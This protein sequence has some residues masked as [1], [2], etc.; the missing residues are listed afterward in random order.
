MVAVVQGS[1][2]Q[3]ESRGNLNGSFE[4]GRNGRTPTGWQVVR[5]AGLMDRKSA[6][7][8]KASLRVEAADLSDSR[9]ES[10]PIELEIGKLYEVR[11]WVRT[12]QLA[13]RDL[14]RSPVA[15]GAAISMASLPFDYHSESIG[16]SRGWTRLRL[17]F[18]ATRAQ[19][20]VV[21]LVGP[22][23]QVNGRA[24][25]DEIGVEEAPTA[26]EWP[27]DS[28]LQTFGPAYRYPKAGW[29]YLHIEGQPYE[30]GYQHGYLLAPEIGRYLDRCALKLDPHSKARAWQLARTMA[31]ALFL[32]GYDKEILEEMRGIADGAASQGIRFGDRRIDL[33]DVVAI[34]SLTEIDFIRAALPMTPTGLEGLEFMPPKYFDPGRDVPPTERCSAFAATGPA[35]RDGKMVIGHITMW[36]LTLSEQTNIMLDVKPAAGRRILMQSYPAGIQ[37]GMDYYQNDAGI[38]LTE[39][40]IRQSPFNISG[41]PEAFRARKSVQYGTSIEEVVELLGAFNNGLL[42]NEWLIGDAKNNQIAMYELGT[43]KRKVYRSSKDEWF[44]GTKGFYWGCNNAKDLSVR[45]E[46]AP[47]PL[48][49]PAHLPFVP[50]VRDIKWQQLYEEYQGRI[51]EQFG[52]LAFRTT[53]LVMPSAFDAK[54][55]TADMAQKMMCW[56]V[57]G[58]PNQLERVPSDAEKRIYPHIRGIYP[59]GYALFQAEPSA[60]LAVA[61]KQREASRLTAGRPAQRVATTKT[62]Y[63]DRVW[64]GWILPAGDGDV[65]LSAG[66]AAYHEALASADWSE[67][68]EVHRALYL[69]AAL[70]RDEPVIRLKSD[71]RSREWFQLAASKGVLLLDALRRQVGDDRFFE[72]MK[73][74]FAAETTKAVDSATF[75]TALDKALGQAVRDGF[76]RWLEGT[77]VPDAGPGTRAAGAAHLLSSVGD[78]IQ[79][80]VLVYGTTREAGANRY[81]AERL[82]RQYLNRYERQ[83]PILKDFEVTEDDVRFHDLIFVGRPETN[84]ALAEMAERI[85]VTYT[86]AMFRIDGV[87]YASGDEALALATANP[88]DRSRMVMVVAGNSALETVRAAEAGPERYEYAI[89]RLGKRVAEGFQKY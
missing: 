33:E 48:G 80:A 84:S 19:D 22:G 8:G 3:T 65:W 82:Q 9:V 59:S 41:T 58:K 27:R 46:Y 21:C 39:T 25:F 40:T 69:G 77:G 16:G 38:V 29:I 79:N 34:N 13:V 49:A 11:A 73:G 70:R 56:A 78:R 17:R 76:S 88:D 75:L 23:G 87:D 42:T 47:D 68:I 61:I 12:D 54:L 6:H 86:G 31:N 57:F 72:F 83:V 60:E 66:A 35:T 67:A 7:D 37:S 89:Y 43:Y 4:I 28:A 2:L 18:V 74:F 10:A 30:R 24:W 85:G 14:D 26:G 55:T 51:D 32:R 36:P 62:S 64:K 81:A 20:R 71:L 63:K 1:S 44:G 15:I 50:S 52:F 5:G 45:L 53:P